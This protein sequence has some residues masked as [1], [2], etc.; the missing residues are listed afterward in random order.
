MNPACS[1]IYLNLPKKKTKCAKYIPKNAIYTSPEIQNQII[2][3]LAEVVREQVVS[4][5]KST[6]VKWFTLL[7]DGTRDTNNRENISIGIRYVKSGKVFESF[8]GI[9]T[10]EKLNAQTFT[11]LT[12]DILNKNKIDPAHIISQ[13]YD[14]ASV[15]SGRKG[16]VAA[17]IEKSVGRCVPYVHCF[18]H[19]LH[20]VVVR[21]VT[22]IPILK[23]FFD[24]AILLH[25][26]FGHGKIAAIYKGKTIVRLLEQRWSGHLT[27]VRVIYSNYSEILRT[28][29]EIRKDNSFNGQDVA[30]SRGIKL[31][32]L[33]IDFRFSLVLMKKILEF[34]KPADAILQERS[35]SLKDANCVILSVKSKIQDLRSDEVLQT[36]VNEAMHLCSEVNSNTENLR[37]R[38]DIKISGNMKN[39]LLTE[40]LPSS[41][42]GM[43]SNLDDKIK[44]AFFETVDIISNLLK[45]RFTNNDELINA[46]SSLDEINMEKLKYFENIGIELPSVEE[47]TVVKDF[48][49]GKPLDQYFNILYE[50][51]VA[52]QKTYCLYAA[53]ATIGCSTAVNESSFSTLTAI[54]RP[55]RYSMNQQ[56]MAD[57]IYLAFGRQ[58][59]REIDFDLFLRKF[60]NLK[61]RSLQLF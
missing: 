17:L 6:D 39:Y 19:R 23:H 8:L 35:T 59:S 49:H 47:I 15:M 31:V 4:D 3:I 45:D 22:E 44:S 27:V 9:Y 33:E 24:Q 55:Q 14:G 18:N 32:M 1:K 61:N 12:L 43:I 2:S 10:T 37:P 60:N 11:K 46:V 53:V 36:L 5:L 51:R 26:F 41:S 21:V 13:C 50:N 28:L 30:K 38:R 52:F 48:L 20:L 57:L 34:L 29:D 56:R 25:K 42:S 40:P 58:R 7:E 16:G 54:N